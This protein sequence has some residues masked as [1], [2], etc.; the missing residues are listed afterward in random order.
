MAKPCRFQIPAIGLLTLALP[1]C[2]PGYTYRP[3]DANG[4][5][6]NR[7]SETIDGVS[8]QGEFYE[9][10]S[11]DTGALFDLNVANH[12]D[13]KVVFLGGELV[14]KGRTMRVTLPGRQTRAFAPGASGQVL[15]DCN[16]Q[17]QGGKASD[18][19]GESITFKWRVRI[20]EEERLVRVKM[21]RD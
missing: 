20:G 11:N 14:T 1:G 2:S 16:Y 9:A 7:W 18:V 10:L 15:I 19:L 8:F 3:A 21:E 4:R 12:S 6:V 5:P 17:Q 13:E